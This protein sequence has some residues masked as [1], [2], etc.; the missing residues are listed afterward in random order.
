MG[1]EIDLAES[2]ID[3]VFSARTIRSRLGDKPAIAPFK[4]TLA[5]GR[6]RLYGMFTEGT[7]AHT[8][9][10]AL[11]FLAGVWLV[12]A[13]Y[14]LDQVDP[15]GVWIGTAVGIA[16]AVVAVVRM[17]APARTA[18]VG[19]VNVGLGA[20]LV[21]LPLVLAR[22]PLAARNDVVVGVL[23]IVFAAASTLL[24][25]RARRARRG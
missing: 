12:V 21:V 4:Q 13:P 1:A 7:S 23:L 5:W 3:S 19:I 14:A 10:S 25:R 16:V 6:E 18:A 2:D 22:P 9:V 20:W 24:G 8:L 11:S 17:L 15:A